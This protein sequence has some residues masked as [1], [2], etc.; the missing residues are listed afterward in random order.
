MIC[1]LYCLLGAFCSEE[2]ID[3]LGIYGASLVLLHSGWTAS[4]NAP[5]PPCASPKGLPNTED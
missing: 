4:D 3:F 1:L 5:R 2:S